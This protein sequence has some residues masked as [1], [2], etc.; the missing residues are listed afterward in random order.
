VLDQVGAVLDPGPSAF[1]CADIDFLE[2]SKNHFSQSL[3]VGK[4]AFST[5]VSVYASACCARGS[6][7]FEDSAKTQDLY[8]GHLPEQVPNLQ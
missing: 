5:S 6:S 7:L 2:N 4:R 3:L 8:R 1:R